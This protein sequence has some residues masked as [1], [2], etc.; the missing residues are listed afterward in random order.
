MSSASSNPKASFSTARTARSGSS[1][2]ATDRTCC[3]GSL[4]P[5]AAE[6]PRK[7]DCLPIGLAVD[8]ALVLGTHGPELKKREAQVLSRVIRSL[9]VDQRTQCDV[10]T[11]Q[12]LG[13]PTQALPNSFVAVGSADVGLARL[14]IVNDADALHRLQRDA[15]I[16][17]VLSDGDLQLAAI[18]FSS[19]LLKASTYWCTTAIGS[20][21]SDT[22]VLLCRGAIEV[23]PVFVE[24]EVAVPHLWPAGW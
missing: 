20:F 6:R 9:L 22:V 19:P 5:V 21:E 3:L 15:P 4:I 13:I 7:K 8:H 18:A 2:V 23:V 11:V 14:L 17:T 10:V 24:F 16:G 1:P 12:R